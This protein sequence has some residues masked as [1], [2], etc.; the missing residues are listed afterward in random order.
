MTKEMLEDSK[1]ET[2]S[3]EEESQRY[4]KLVVALLESISFYILYT[5]LDICH[6]ILVPNIDVMTI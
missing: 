1:E 6:S 5:L 4:V 2:A 3:L